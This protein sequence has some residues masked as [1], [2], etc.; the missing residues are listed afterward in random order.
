MELNVEHNENE[1]RFGARKLLILKVG[2]AGFEPTASCTPSKRA[3]RLRHVPNSSIES[4]YK[5]DQ[6]V[7]S[8]F[9]VVNKSSAIKRKRRIVSRDNLDA[10]GDVGEAAGC[11]GGCIGGSCGGSVG[12]GGTKSLAVAP[13]GTIFSFVVPARDSLASLRLAPAIVKP[14]S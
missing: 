13:G 6:L 9:R 10:S 7:S 12:G 5:A 14:S 1:R 4:N 11:V 2:T 8:W 3:T